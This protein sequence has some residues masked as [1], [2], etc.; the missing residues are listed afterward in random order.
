MVLLLNGTKDFN[1]ERIIDTLM[2]EII[3]VTIVYDL[4]KL[5]WTMLLC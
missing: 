2:L 5:F 1:Y 3:R 4:I